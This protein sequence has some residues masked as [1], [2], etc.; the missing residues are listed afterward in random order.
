MKI[1]YKKRALQYLQ[2]SY[3]II[4]LSLKLATLSLC[5]TVQTVYTQH[6]QHLLCKD[7]VMFFPHKI[8]EGL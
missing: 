4:L 3:Y 5:V 1:F 8:A 2:S 6:L 7:M